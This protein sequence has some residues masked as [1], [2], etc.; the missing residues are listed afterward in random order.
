MS[1]ITTLNDWITWNSFRTQVNTN[2]SNLNTDKAELSGGTFTWDISVPDEAYGVGWNWSMEVP[3]KNALYD[4]IETISGGGSVATDAIWDAK[5]DLAWGT[6]VN[7]A[8]RLPIGTNGQVL[9]ADSAE[10]TGLKWS[11]PAGGG[12]ALTSGTLAQFA[13]TTSLELKGVISDETGSGSL[14]FATSPTLVTPVLGVA[15]ATSIN[16][17]TITSGTLNGS[18]TG[19][20]TGDNAT[21]TT[22]TTLA[23][24]LSTANTWSAIQTFLSGMFGLRNVANTFTSFFTNTN[25]ASRTYTLKDASWT[26]AFTTDITGTN[27]GTNTGDQTSIVGITGTKAQFD[28]ACTDGNFLY[29][30]DLATTAEINTGTANKPMP[31]DQYVASNRNVRYIDI[32]A[33]D[34]ATDNA[35]GTNICGAFE[36]PFTG[37]ITEIGAYVETAWVTGTSVWDVNKNGTTIMTTNKL[38]IDSAEVS[39][40]TAATAP[41]LTTTAITAGDLLTIDTDSLSTTKPKGFHLRIWIRLT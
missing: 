14:V 33:I 12:D 22:Y 37:T 1:T 36:C 40:R 39:T 20:N 16:G 32:Y 10:A 18:V 27:S 2:F 19:T 35:V 5:G 31:V 29:S 30:G 25:T 9:T 34:K 23:T 17:A 26:L 7:T 38:S 6:G 4:K 28:T 15:T 8:S 11:N 3:T 24:T 21:N 13:S 41:T